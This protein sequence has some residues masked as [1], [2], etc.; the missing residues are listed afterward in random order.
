MICV[1]DLCIMRTC[2]CMHVY[3]CI[4]MYVCTYVHAHI[5]CKCMCVSPETYAH[6]YHVVVFASLMH[7]T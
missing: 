2:V 4:Y 5:K 7:A 6:V 1:R 3:V